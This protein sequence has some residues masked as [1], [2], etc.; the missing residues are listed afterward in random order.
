MSTI[1]TAIAGYGRNWVE[2]AGPAANLNLAQATPSPS[3]GVHPT[4]RNHG[5]AVDRDGSILVA[6][7]ANSVVGR[8]D[9][10][11]TWT[12][13]PLPAGFDEPTAALPWKVIAAAGTPQ[14]VLEPTA[15]AGKSAIHWI[16][17]DVARDTW[18][19]VVPATFVGA[20]VDCSATVAG[21]GT[22]YLDFW[23]GSADIRTQA[24]TLSST[25]QTLRLTATVAGNT[26]FQIRTPS[27][28]PSV[29][30]TVW[31]VSVNQHEITGTA[32]AIAGVMNRAGALDDQRRA[33]SARLN[34]PTAVAAD[35]TGTL[36][37]ADTYNNA[38]RAVDTDGRI[39]TLA[40]DLHHPC[41]VAV[42]ADGTV[43]VADTYASVVGR[44]DKRG[45]LQAVAGTGEAGYG[46]DG[47]PGV[48]AQ[49]D[50]PTGIAA[51]EGS[52]YIADTYN[53]RVRVVDRHGRIRT[54]AGTGVAGRAGDGGPAVQAQLHAPHS[55]AVAAG[56]RCYIADTV[57]NVIRV[58]AGGTIST[59]AGTGAYGTSGQNGGAATSAKLAEPLGVAVDDRTA[60]VYVVDSSQGVLMLTS[61]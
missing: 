42:D 6:A 34:Y 2:F 3:E 61:G 30:V 57:N 16:G 45:R 13:R 56:G 26:Q 23:T 9:A 37:I 59:F 25:P 39:R 55:V 11:A 8:I 60:T 12:D 48:R 36:Y 19:Y 29:D 52:L 22:V 24:I 21:E 5:I 47:G 50:H 54:V 31:D 32:R 35:K 53:H 38:I 41:G 14:Y 1:I 18:L 7:T 49:L 4:G 10:P 15:V 27:A 58:I 44:L 17:T 51:T 20:T 43:Y 28:Q 33:L 46:G 40:E